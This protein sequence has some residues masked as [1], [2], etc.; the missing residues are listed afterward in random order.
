M[1]RIFLYPYAGPGGRN[2]FKQIGTK[3]GLDLN[4]VQ[5]HEGM[6]LRFYC[7]D[8][9]DAGK[10]DDLFFEGIIHYDTDKQQWYV[11]VDESSY[12]HASDLD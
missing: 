3:Q 12:R 1:E 9:N 7:D 8:A 5:L 6:R 10:S 2:Y 11:V 4:H